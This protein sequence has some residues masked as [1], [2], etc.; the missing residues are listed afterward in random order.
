[1]FFLLLTYQ[2]FA[3]YDDIDTHSVRSE[4][5]ERGSFIGVKTQVEKSVKND[6]IS[7]FFVLY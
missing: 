2:R 3:Y 5:N 1:M 7:N 4:V 6:C